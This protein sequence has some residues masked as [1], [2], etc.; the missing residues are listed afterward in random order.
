MPQARGHPLRPVAAAWSAQGEVAVSGDRGAVSARIEAMRQAFAEA[1]QELTP[2]AHH[3]LS[4]YSMISGATDEAIAHGTQAFELSLAKGE[5][6]WA[7]LYAALLAQVLSALGETDLA[8]ARAE[9][10]LELMKELGTRSAPAESALGNALSEVDPDRALP[11]LEAGVALSEEQGNEAIWF[12][13]G[14]TLAQLEAGRGNRRRALELFDVLL[15]RTLESR[16]PLFATLTCSTL[17]LVLARL[18]LYERAALVVFGAERLA[19]VLQ[20]VRRARYLEAVELV[21]RGLDDDAFERSAERGRAMTTEELVEFARGEV[22][23]MLAEE[24]G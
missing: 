8:V 16:N 4:S 12:V 21:R 20:G 7:A 10:A 24:A 2:A 17:G 23:T 3:A 9:R 13:S 11:H 1:D 14:V 22:R 18:G 15:D 19:A 5:R 6:R